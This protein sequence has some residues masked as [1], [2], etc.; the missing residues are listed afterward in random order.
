MEQGG[1]PQLM[2]PELI[3][4]LTAHALNLCILNHMAHE[5]LN[6][7]GVPTISRTA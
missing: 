1:H 6:A 7:A 4:T 5:M 3:L 2:T